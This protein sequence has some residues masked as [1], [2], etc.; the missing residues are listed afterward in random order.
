MQLLTNRLLLRDFVA[1]D[2][3]AVLAY[4]RDPRYLRLYEWT[5]RR[6]EDARAFVDMFIAQQQQQPRTRFQLAVTLRADGRLIG[7]CGIRL[8]A[9]GS[10]QAWPH[11]AEIGYELAPD[12][13][14]HGYATEAAQ[15]IVQFGI[16]QL[17][18][19]R[20]EAWTVADNAASARV[21]T[22]LGFVEEGRLPQYHFYKGRYWDAVV[23]GLVIK[24]ETTDFTD[25]AD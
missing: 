12:E 11:R 19:T 15:A 20:L 2:W 7:N 14:G 4:Q 21:L 23:Y 18:V 16:E 9:P 10:G 3:P 8:A 25:Y 13:W 5:E 1:G 22:K 17:G 24:K 6:E